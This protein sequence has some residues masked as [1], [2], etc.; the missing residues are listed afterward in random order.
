MEWII[1]KCVECNSEFK[2]PSYLLQD[3]E[4]CYSC[5]GPLVQVDNKSKVKGITVDL[6]IDTSKVVEKINGFKSALSQVP[7]FQIELE[8][9]TS[10]PKVFYK[11]EEIKYKKIVNFD[12]ETQKEHSGTGGLNLNIEH[13]DKDTQ[14]LRIIGRKR[15]VYHEDSTL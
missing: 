13:Y 8:D 12:W 10:V 5:N 1:R 9:E 2:T 15:G 3:A 14:S 11:G 6:D 7:L 4:V